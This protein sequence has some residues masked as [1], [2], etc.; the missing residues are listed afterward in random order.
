MYCYS[1]H[2]V[3]KSMQWFVCLCVCKKI[4]DRVIDG[5]AR[6]LICMDQSK[7]CTLDALKLL[8]TYKILLKCVTDSTAMLPMGIGIGLGTLLVF[9]LLFFYRRQRIQKQKQK[10][11]QK[12]ASGK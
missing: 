3:K 10:Q 1:L 4:S 6:A 12:Q 11:K 5:I 2:Q 7:H 9:A 8:L